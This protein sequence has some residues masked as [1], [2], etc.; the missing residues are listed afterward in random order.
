M[1]PTGRLFCYSGEGFRLDPST[2][3]MT[4]IPG[5]FPVGSGNAVF[6]PQGR[7]LYFSETNTATISGYSI[8]SSS[9]MLSP[10]PGF[11]YTL[12]ASGFVVD[13]S[14]K[15]LVTSDGSTYAIDQAS[16]AL[17]PKNGPQFS[18]ISGLAF[19]PPAP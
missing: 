12:D 5:S 16:G 19:Y 17:T 6:D 7:Y 15:L 2:G 8:D 1:D 18:N 3:A 9:G 10:L 4:Q 13:P 14:G 11:P